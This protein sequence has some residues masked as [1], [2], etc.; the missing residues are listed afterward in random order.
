[1]SNNG[2]MGQGQGKHSTPPRLC[3]DLETMPKST[4]QVATRVWRIETPQDAAGQR[5][6]GFLGKALAG[7]GL[8]RQRIKAWI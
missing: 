6:D 5:L 3:R 2:R 1:M 8:S 4:P 7:Q